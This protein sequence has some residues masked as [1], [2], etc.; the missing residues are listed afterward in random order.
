MK[1]NRSLVK[2]HLGCGTIAPEGWINIDGSWNAWLAKYSLLKFFLKK[3]GIINQDLLNI[4]WPKN[5]LV[6][7]LTKPLP[8][9]SNS[10]DFIYS[11][12]TIEHIYLY[13]TQ[14]LLK[15]C[16]RVLKPGGVLRIVVPDLYKY[17]KLYLSDQKIRTEDGLSTKADLFLASLLVS[18]PSPKGLLV[19]RMYNYLNDTNSHK[20]MYDKQSLTYWFKWAGFF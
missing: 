16:F 9:K 20:W 1:N 3:I 10:I 8:F 18:S 17:A 4:P 7:N 14:N 19:F 5:I 13:Q 12:H 11:S 6:H 2:L 15:E